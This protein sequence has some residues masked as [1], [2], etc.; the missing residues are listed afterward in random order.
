MNYLDR[1]SDASGH[2]V[3]DDVRDRTDLNSTL[4]ANTHPQ[5]RR[6]AQLVCYGCLDRLLSVACAHARPTSGAFHYMEIALDARGK[7]G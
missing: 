2:P 6:Q 3:L 7:P 4:S 1:K 5:A